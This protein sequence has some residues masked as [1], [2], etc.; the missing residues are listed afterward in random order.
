MGLLSSPHKFKCSGHLKSEGA[1]FEVVCRRWFEP[2]DGLPH[3]IKVVQ[4]LQY[5]SSTFLAISVDAIANQLRNAKVEASCRSG[6]DSS[7]GAFGEKWS[8][9]IGE[10]FRC[11]SV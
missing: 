5:F 10:D 7:I 4:A 6:T 9:V 8:V 1:D 2:L 3:R 11:G